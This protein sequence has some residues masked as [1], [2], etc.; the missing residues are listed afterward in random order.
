MKVFDRMYTAVQNKTAKFFE[1]TIG[2]IRNVYVNEFGRGWRKISHKN[3]CKKDSESILR[4]RGGKEFE[5]RTM[6]AKDSRCLVSGNDL[7]S[8]L[9]K[10]ISLHKDRV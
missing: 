7:L 10:C 3:N 9:G 5:K 8:A 4:K 2:T 6:D 1:H